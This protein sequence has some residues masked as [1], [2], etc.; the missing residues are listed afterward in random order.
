MKFVC[1]FIQVIVRMVTNWELLQSSDENFFCTCSDWKTGTLL[2]ISS[3]FV[4]NL[5]WYGSKFSRCLY[6]LP[7]IVEGEVVGVGEL[8]SR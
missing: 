1:L 4:V 3:V 6:Q 5:I 7:N 2:S 8:D